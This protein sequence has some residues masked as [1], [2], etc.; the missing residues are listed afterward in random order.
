MN[1]KQAYIALNLLPHIGPVR[2]HRLLEHFGNPKSILSAKVEELMQVKGIGQEAS[3]SIA[4]WRT[5]ID[6][7]DELKKIQAR[8]IG[9]ITTEDDNYPSLLK[10]IYAPPI[11]LYIWGRLEKS[12]SD[13][14]SI[15]GSRQAT[16]YGKQ[17]ARKFGFQ[18]AHAGLCVIS[19]LARGIDSAAHEGALAAGG[20]TIA[21]IG[22]GLGKLYPKENQCLAEKISRNGAVIS[23]FPVDFPPQKRSFP[24][25]NRIVAGWGQGTLVI[26]AGAKSGALITAGQ[27]SD[28]NRDVYAVPGQVDRQESQGANRLIQQGAKLVIDAR[29]VLEEMA[30]EFTDVGKKPEICSSRAKLMSN[31]EKIIYGSLGPDQAHIDEVSNQVNMG[32]AEVSATL[33]KLEI[34]QLVKQLPGNYFVK[35]V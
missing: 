10:K 34:K 30:I 23:E 32:V 19:G 31:S 35:L 11:V 26:E 7:Q 14:I 22:S 6:L 24:Q 5:L 15:V 17:T 8:D 3:K 21:V 25:R 27:A 4:N 1:S 33:L 2:V 29:D 20:R 18:L 9:I 28:S 13:A 16:Y 12:D